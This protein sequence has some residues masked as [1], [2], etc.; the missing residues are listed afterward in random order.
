MGNSLLIAIRIFDSIVF[1]VLAGFLVEV[2]IGGHPGW[3]R[4]MAASFGIL[5]LGVSVRL[6]A[7]VFQDDPW[8][9]WSTFSLVSA[10]LACIGFYAAWKDR[11]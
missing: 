11:E 1:M 8:T 9:W 4:W 5:C 2:V 3:R 6:I 10:F 7:R